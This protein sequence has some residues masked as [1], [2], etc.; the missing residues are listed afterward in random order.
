MRYD[1]PGAS[2]ALNVAANFGLPQAILDD[3]RA[4]I[5]QQHEHIEALLQQLQGLHRDLQ[6]EQ[7]RLKQHAE[8]QQVELQRWERDFRHQR[9][10]AWSTL[11]GDAK[12]LKAQL[13]HARDDL[14]QMR[15]VF[16]QQSNVTQQDI[17][18]GHAQ[19]TEASAQLEKWQ[20]TQELKPASP[21][22][23]S[24]VVEARTPAVGDRVW[25][26]D[27][28]QEGHVLELQSNKARA[29]IAMGVMRVW[30]AFDNLRV[31][32]ADAKVDDASAASEYRQQP[33]AEDDKKRH[34]ETALR[35]VDNTVDV[36]GMRVDEAIAMT[37]AF[38]DR[39][40]GAS[41]R[42]VYVLHGVGSGALRDALG[43]YLKQESHYVRGLRAATQDEGGHGV[44]VC[45]LD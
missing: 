39:C 44:T 26:K 25:V 27:L 13:Q 36:R 42:V 15:K 16:A 18:H 3:A 43:E 35:T 19:V 17:D 7:H 45:L 33:R 12:E 24:P 31:L 8:T 21:A 11:E 40:Y 14:R 38:L 9:Q 1:L 29:R 22:D 20:N 41:H 37:E 28:R 2:H 32:A 4:R 10:R 5:P 23:H 6:H 34:V 30:C